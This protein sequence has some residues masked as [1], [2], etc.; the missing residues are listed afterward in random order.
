MLRGERRSDHWP[1]RSHL[2]RSRHVLLS[3][4]DQGLYFTRLEAMLPQTQGP[5]RDRRDPKWRPKASKTV[6]TAPDR[7]LA[8]P[9]SDPKRPPRP[10]MA[11]KTLPNR[12]DVSSPTTS[13]GQ[14]V[15]AVAVGPG[16]FG[17]SGKAFWGPV[18]FG[19]FGFDVLQ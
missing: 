1:H 10:K 5:P 13:F 2:C 18:R 11:S 6:Q 12:P 15:E 17:L 7:P 3:L 19:G 9:R 14:S 4:P 16:H 8:R